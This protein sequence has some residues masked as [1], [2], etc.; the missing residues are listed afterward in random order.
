MDAVVLHVN[1]KKGNEMKIM[2]ISAVAA[3]VCGLCVTAN[4]GEAKEKRTLQGNMNQVYNVLPSSVDNISD[5]FSKGMFYGQL[6]MNA[7]KW[8]WKNDNTASTGNKDGN[9]VAVGG[10]LIYKTAPLAGISATA[11]LYYSQNTQEVSQ[12]D[13]TYAKSGKDTFSRYDAYNGGDFDMAV[14]AQAYVQYDISKTSLKFGRQAF[15]SFLLA[16]NDTKMIPNTFEGVSVESKDIDKTTLKGAYFTAQKLRDHT[17]FHDVLTYGDGSTNAKA[18]WNGNDDSGVHQGLTYAKFANAGKSVN[19]KLVVAEVNNKS[20]KNLA[21]D[22]SYTAVPDVIS[23]L[24]GEVNYT[25]DL[26]SGYSLTPGA[27]YMKQIDNGGGLVGGPSLKGDVTSAVTAAAK[28][29]KKYDSLDGS[30]SMARLVLSKGALKTQVAYSAVEDAADIVAPWR[31]FPTGGYTR[32]MAQLNWKANTKSY[33]AEV[34]YDFGKANILPGFTAMARYVIQDFDEKKQGSGAEADSKILHVDLKQ[35]I[36]KAL[37][38]KLRLGFKSANAQ[39]SGIDK[40]SYNEYRF[41]LN[42]L[43]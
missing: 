42:Y 22:V 9:Q 21:V 4:A 40:D 36:T 31:G 25:V 24:M 29:Y 38:A 43:F 27:R 33:D 14:L 3:L 32:A 23:S 39:T 8:D 1:Q 37:D 13:I 16:S 28:G 11:G 35:Q 19:H 17:T 10:S 15:E 30:V 20:I 7:F 6:R 5:A 41:E 26:G 2:K 18:T 34:T 12:A